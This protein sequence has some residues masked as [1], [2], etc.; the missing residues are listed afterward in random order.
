MSKPADK[1]PLLDRLAVVLVRPQMS[2]N[3]G[4]TARA[5]ANMGCPHLVVVSP[6]NWQP[7]RAR[8]LATTTGHHILESVRWTDSVEE[9]LAPFT[10]TYGAT[11]RTGGWRK[12]LT[13]PAK[14][15]PRILDD[16]LTASTN[17]HDG[18][19]NT[20]IVFGPEN[21]G[22]HNDD[23]EHLGALINIPTAPEASSLNLAQAVLLILYEVFSNALALTPG[24]QET[25][26]DDGPRINHA[27][28]E[29][30]FRFIEDTLN[31]IDFLK[32]D[33]PDYWM[34]PIRRF[35]TRLKLKRHEFNLLM[36][37]C[38]QVKWA[39]KHKK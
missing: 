8:A 17:K 32:D 2:E 36:G 13:N 28:A 27:E 1:P 12:Y 5:M 34:L 16:M 14:A 33:N 26:E 22:L 19:P 18:T 3:I 4:A 35:I 38:R 25:H 10:A 31:T 29:H 9:A 23:I 21:A 24:H 6:Q 20:A 39:V 11:A 7:D 15:A 37:L 30:L